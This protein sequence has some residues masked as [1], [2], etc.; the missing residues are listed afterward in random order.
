MK[1]SHDTMAGTKVA[2]AGQPMK[3]P[4]RHVAML[5]SNSYDTDGRVRREVESL[6]HQGLRVT[7]IAWDRDG[8]KPLRQ[9]MDGATIIRLRNSR[10]MNFLRYDLLRLRFWNGQA[11]RQLLLVAREEPVDL[12]HAHDLDTLRAGIRCKRAL[13]VPL[14]YDAH[15]IW[16]YMIAKD[17]PAFLARHFLRSEKR[18]IRSVDSVITV[19]PPLM[20]YFRKICSAPVNLVMNAKPSFT[21]AFSP[22]RLSNP[23]RLFFAGTINQTRLIQELVQAVSGVAGIQ[24]TIAGPTHPGFADTFDKECQSAPNVD[25]LGILPLDQVVRRT[26]DS[27]AVC[28]LFSPDDPLTRI[29]MPNKLFEA[30]AAG[31]ALISTK[32][33]YLGE[34]VEQHNIG[35]AFDGNVEG[36]R[37]AIRKLFE[38]PQLVSEMGRRAF[39]LGRGEHSWATQ[40][41]RLLKAYDSLVSGRLDGVDSRRHGPS[42]TK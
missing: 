23:F 20:E 36:I 26:F 13:R 16:G 3:K 2:R 30:L 21:T 17:V 31:R 22:P 6:V 28:C 40:E 25:Y 9:S 39:D 38:N 10:W 32:G 42:A 1:C 27:D 19:S 35:V 4:Q 11:A 7:V 15:E 8:N 41:K 12:I 14:L 5:L 34:F 37:R 18:L 33:T 24:L 29:G